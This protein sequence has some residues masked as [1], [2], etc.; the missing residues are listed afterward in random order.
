MADREHERMFDPVAFSRSIRVR[1]A[2]LNIPQREAARVIGVDKSVLHRVCK[3]SRPPDV[4][5]YLR[6]SAWMEGTSRD[7]ERNTHG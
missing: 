3:Y 7:R 6:I 5:N 4:E 1:L 2:E